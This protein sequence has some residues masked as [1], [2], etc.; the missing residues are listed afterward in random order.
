MEA[1]TNKIAHPATVAL[2]QS[3]QAGGDAGAVDAIRRAF[4]L[5][6]EPAHEERSAAALVGLEAASGRK[7]AQ[8]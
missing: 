6:E 7:A 8:E 5:D 1:L 2:R 3:A 4:G